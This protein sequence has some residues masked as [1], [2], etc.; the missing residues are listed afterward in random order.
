MDIESD[1]FMEL[2]TEALRSG[3]ASPPWRQA[4]EILH[5][6]GEKGEDYT[7]LCRVR[8]NLESGKSYRTV[9]A[10]SGFTRKLMHRLDEPSG[11]RSGIPTAAIIAII[12]SAAVVITIV[13]MAWMLIAPSQNKTSV[14]QLRDTFFVSAL[15]SQS[16]ESGIPPEFA[17]IGRLPLLVL[18][19][20]KM[21]PAW[22]ANNRLAGGGLYF[23]HPLAPDHTYAVDCTFEIP[24]PKSDLIAQI[25][26]CDNPTFSP[27]KGVSQKEL[28]CL[29]QH[30][31][32]RVI[33]PDGKTVAESPLTLDAQATASVSVKFNHELVVVE[34]A[35]KILY[36]G[37]HQL[38][39]DK[40][41]LVGLRFLTHEGSNNSAV[42]IRS[43]RV[44]EP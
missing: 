33:L 29:T 30:G 6:A 36:A 41:R 5:A 22:K 14:A 4:I 1:T 13:I 17:K 8:E 37:A 16:F 18:G 26:L 31:K 10:G 7:L 24:D 42:T 35:G 39:G 11:H 21:D 19:G 32:L 9:H 40:Q 25:F 38:S 27:D 43:L 34:H 20:V 44:M 2:L 28:V 3:P 23:K 12:A 15:V